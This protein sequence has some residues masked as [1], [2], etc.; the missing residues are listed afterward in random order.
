M[1]KF[2]IFIFII[3][4]SFMFAKSLNFYSYSLLLDY[5]EYQNG[6]VIDKDYSSFGDIVGA[7]IEYRDNWGPWYLSLKFEGSWGSSTYEG[8]TWNGEPLKNKQNGFYL[9]NLNAAI[10]SRYLF[11]TLGYR[12]WNR[13]K[14]EF[15][16]DYDEVYYWGYWG[17]KYEY[18]FIFENIAFIPQISYL[19]AIDPKMKAKLGNEPVLDLGNTIGRNIILPLFFK[20]DNFTFNIFYRFEY[21]HINP[22]NAYPL[23]LNGNTYYIYEPESETKNQYIGAGL[24]WRF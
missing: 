7:G 17:L 9:Y 15:S 11:L 4:N 12:E 23:I 1:K 19:M 18:P 13:G 21:W 20:T 5:K 3:F 8:A 10:G 2:L 14:S 6:V 16:G 22:S 24:L